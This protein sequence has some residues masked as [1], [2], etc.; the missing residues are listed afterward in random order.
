MICG[1]A[2]EANERCFGVVF[3]ITTGRADGF[4]DFELDFFRAILPILALTLRVA[5]N[6]RFS[7]AVADAYLGRDAARRVLNGEIDRGH[8]ETVSA[9]LFFLRFVRL[10]RA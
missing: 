4:S 6:R 10:H 8:V 9:V 5:A 7:Q 2:V 1:Y 3:T